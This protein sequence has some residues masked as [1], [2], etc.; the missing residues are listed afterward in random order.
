MSNW[1]TPADTPPPLGR[2]A[3]WMGRVLLAS[4][5]ILAGAAKIANPERT[6]EMMTSG[7]VP[8]PEVVL[9]IVIALELFGGFA[10]L[11][12]PGVAGA[13]AAVILAGF[14][15]ATN[16]VAH[17]FWTFAGER[18]ALE[19]SLF[20]KNISIAGGLLVLAGVLW[21]R[22]RRGPGPVADPTAGPVA[23][24]VD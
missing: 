13:A 15:L 3:F 14:T 24:P 19:L 6:L 10:V 1:A 5:F 23:D 12:T 4:L 21:S 22:R 7:G 20:F 9:P 8:Q 2:A 17:Q 11:T 18:Q 16:V